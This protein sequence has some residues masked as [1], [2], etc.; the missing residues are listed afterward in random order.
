MDINII[1][2]FQNHWEFSSFLQNRSKYF[3]SNIYYKYLFLRL[4]IMILTITMSLKDKHMY[5]INMFVIRSEL[6]KSL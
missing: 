2:C 1:S 6:T 4:L 5:S 3:D